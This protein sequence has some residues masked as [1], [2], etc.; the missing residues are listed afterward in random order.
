MGLLNSLM[1]V[2]CS[3][4]PHRPT[5]GEAGSR[6]TRPTGAEEQMRYFATLDRLQQE[7]PEVLRLMTEVFQLLKPLS[8]C[9]KNRCAA[10]C[11]VG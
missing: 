2:F 1:P 8:I 4:Q 5:D 3:A 9:S 10:T 11:S 6:G 7:D